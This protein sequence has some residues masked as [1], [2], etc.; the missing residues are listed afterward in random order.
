MV[1]FWIGS[2]FPGC[3]SIKIVTCNFWWNFFVCLFSTLSIQSNDQI[4]QIIKIIYFMVINQ[5]IYHFKSTSNYKLLERFYIKSGTSSL[6]KLVK[7]LTFKIKKKKSILENHVSR[8]LTWFCIRWMLF[9]MFC[10]LWLH[11]LWTLSQRFSGW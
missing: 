2:L 7:Y 8:K 10:I 4:F 6:N 9:L 5:L 3:L 1:G 11:A